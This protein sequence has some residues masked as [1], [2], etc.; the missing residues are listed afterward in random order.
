[1]QENKTYIE[2][3]T[4]EIDDEELLP[5]QIVEAKGTYGSSLMYYIAKN[6]ETN[7]YVGTVGKI[8]ETFEWD[9]YSEEAVT[10]ILRK[11]YYEIKNGNE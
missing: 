6:E 7:K 3:E 10:E 9:E 11:H 2:V 5:S 4:S 1:M 8:L